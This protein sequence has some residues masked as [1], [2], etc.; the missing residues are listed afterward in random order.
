MLVVTLVAYGF[1]FATGSSLHSWLV[2]ARGGEDT[3]L[4]VGFYYAANAAG[5]VVGLA[6]SAVLYAAFG[7]G[8]AGMVACLIGAAVAAAVAALCSLPL[9]RA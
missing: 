2:V 5:R 4:R 6:A 1:V 8:S 7:Q 3:A 9:R